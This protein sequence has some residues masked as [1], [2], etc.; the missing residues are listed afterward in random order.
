MKISCEERTEEESKD[1]PTVM[2]LEES[3]AHKC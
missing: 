1:W 3:Q 2:G